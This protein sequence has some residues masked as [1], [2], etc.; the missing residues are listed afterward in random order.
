MQPSC[1]TACGPN[2]QLNADSTSRS[3]TPREPSTLLLLLV[4]ELLLLLL[5]ARCSCW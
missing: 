3:G 4:L 2:S 5:R 1:N